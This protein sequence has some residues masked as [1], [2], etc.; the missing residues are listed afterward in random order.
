MKKYIAIFLVLAGIVFGDQM[1]IQ[2]KNAAT[3]VI[4]YFVMR[5]RTADTVDTGVTIANLVMYYVEDQ[6]A[7]SAD[8]FAQAHGGV[9]DAH[10][11]GEC[12]HVGQGVYRVDWPDAAFDGGIGKRVQLIVIDGDA[13]AFTEIM[14]VQL[15]PPADAVALSGDATAADNLEATYDGTGYAD[16]NAP[17]TQV[18]LTGIGGGVSIATVATGRTLAEGDETL[19]Y[20]ATA[21]HDGSYYEVAS[22]TTPEASDDIDFQLIFNTGD[23]MNFPIF[24]HLHG[25]Y[26]DNNAPANSTLTIEAWNFD[27][28]AWEGI[29]VLSDSA[30]DIDLN[31]PLHTHNVDPD[32]GNEGEVRIRFKLDATEENQNMRI[33]HAS[34]NYVSGAVSAADVV[35]EWESQSQA[36]PV[37][38]HVNVKQL[39][40][41]SV[42]QASGYIKISDGTGTGQLDLTAGGVLLADVVQTI[43]RLIIDTDSN[44]ALQVTSGGNHGASFTGSGSGGGVMM[45]GGATGH[46]LFARGGDTSGA[47]AYFHGAD[48]GHGDGIKAESGSD[49][50]YGFS[51]TGDSGDIQAT[52]INDIL[53]DTSAI[54]TGAEWLGLLSAVDTDATSATHA[55][56]YV[57]LEAGKA[58]NDA[59]NG[60]SISVTDATDGN[61]ETRRIEDWTSGL[62]ATFDRAL[63]F[64][65]VQNDLV[66]IYAMPYNI[67]AAIAGGS[68][69][70]YI[71]TDT[72]AVGGTGIPDV[73]VWVTADSAGARLVVS[74]VTDTNGEVVFYLD[75]GI[76]YYVW[77]AKSG[78]SFSD[79]GEAWLA[80]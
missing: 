75:A 70:T 77:M 23:G 29:A 2:V 1:G 73:S 55:P 57:T 25:Y 58:S 39:D 62:K 14:Q 48:D 28:L 60:Q 74:G 16:D 36:A 20:E 6:A 4:T 52:E 40:G 30:S 56:A 63:S 61:T 33:D 8:V 31:L 68:A 79:N 65:P 12:I 69:N 47:G 10:T 43:D 17:S 78:F 76:T 27:T 53:T 54:D 11:D 18:Q 46:G 71:V 9:T 45:Q 51:M 5:D 35:D 38:F 19:T 22:D 42:Q 64:T 32:G 59:Y 37:G 13:G 49:S 44:V 3:D 41:S 67:T 50:G 7:I 24:F 15:S 21:S 72:G 26:E 66:R 80:D 34:V